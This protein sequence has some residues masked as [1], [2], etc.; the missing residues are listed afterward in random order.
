MLIKKQYWYG[1]AFSALTQ[2]VEQQKE[3]PACK[4]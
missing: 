1:Y 2:L 3:H 4:N